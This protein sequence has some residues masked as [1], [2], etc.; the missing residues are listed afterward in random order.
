MNFLNSAMRTRSRSMSAALC[1]VCLSYNSAC[2][3]SLK[4]A[5]TY[6]FVLSWSFLCISSIGPLMCSV[7]FEVADVTANT[8]T[9]NMRIHCNGGMLRYV[10]HANSSRD[11]YQHAATSALRESMDLTQ[12]TLSSLLANTSYDLVL[13]LVDPQCA[14]SISATLRNVTTAATTGVTGE[15][16]WWT[17]YGM[18]QDNYV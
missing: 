10:V 14:N 2:L 13:Y 17:G 11:P 12:L 7:H 5:C 6:R 9:T 1:I 18:T 15:Y 3:V 4:L 16:A 8:I